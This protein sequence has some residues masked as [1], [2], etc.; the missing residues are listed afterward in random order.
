MS[1]K[2]KKI[3]VKKAAPKSV[4]LPK[5][6]AKSVDKKSE[7]I[8]KNGSYR[9]RKEGNCLRI[10]EICDEQMDK[11]GLSGLY[12]AVINQ[13]EKEH[14]P[15][16]TARQ[17][18]WRWRKFNGI[19]GRAKPVA[20]KM[21]KIVLPKAILSRKKA[22]LKSISKAVKLPKPPAKKSAEVVTTPAPETVPVALPT[23]P[24]AGTV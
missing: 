10:W 15:N 8:K 7:N 20:P 1:K 5:P 19:V 4:K 17:Q 21:P 9:P 16:C 22:V 12:R 14:I 24:T 23:E 6:P 3:A 13:S 18:I 2:T 11:N